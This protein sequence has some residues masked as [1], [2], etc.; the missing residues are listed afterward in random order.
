MN[1]TDTFLSLQARIAECRQKNMD[2]ECEIAKMELE[3]LNP[4]L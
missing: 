3:C 2:L 4:A 1:Q